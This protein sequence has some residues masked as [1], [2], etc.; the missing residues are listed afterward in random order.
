MEDSLDEIVEKTETGYNLVVTQE[1]KQI[2]IELIKEVTAAAR[3]RYKELYPGSG[4]DSSMMAQIWIE[5]F[6]VGAI[7]GCIGAF[8]DIDQ[9]QQLDLEGQA[10]KIL[11][12]FK[13]VS[14]K[15]E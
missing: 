4:V 1:N 15:N 8:L 14:A 7:G 9:N 5:G 11:Q 12:E 13:K 2:W 6:Q 3:K 10:E